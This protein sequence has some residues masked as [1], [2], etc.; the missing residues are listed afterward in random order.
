MDYINYFYQTI[1]DIYNEWYFEHY[2]SSY[3]INDSTINIQHTN[4]IEIIKL[5]KEVEN[6]IR[7]DNEIKELEYRYFNLCKSINEDDKDEDNNKHNND[8]AIKLKNKK[9][10]IEL[11]LKN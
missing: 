2:V 6:E 7:L 1:Y 9:I 8:G 5:I 10:K 4:E 3:K 11:K